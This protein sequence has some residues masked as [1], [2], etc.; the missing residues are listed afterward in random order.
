MIRHATKDDL[1]DLMV[2]AREFAREAPDVYVWDKNKVET[3]LNQALE[4]NH[5]CILVVEDS[6]GYITGGLLG[7]LTEM[8][9]STKVVA[10]ELSW[11]MSKE[12][13]NSKSALG[14]MKEFERWAKDNGA[15]IVAMA[16][17]EG[18]SYLE[19]LYSRKGYSLSERV[20]IKEI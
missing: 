19:A 20:Y 15:N 11:F 8:F 3:I 13:R 10:T 1:F 5:M 14:L 7:V 2:L 6:K 17:L 4:E 12:H 16:D 18:V 9:M